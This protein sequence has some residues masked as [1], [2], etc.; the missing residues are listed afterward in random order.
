[1]SDQFEV[2]AEL[3]EDMGKGASRRLRRFADKIPAIIYGGDKDPQPL[4]IIRKDLEK[5]LENEAFYS[6][7]LSVK[8]GGEDQQAILKDLQ[9][10]PAKN[11][12]MHADFLRVSAKVALK[13]NVPIHF[14]NEETCK[15]VKIE[16]GIIQHQATDIEVS[17]LPAAIPEYIEVDMLDVEIG[18]IVHL[19]DITLPEGVTSTALALGED[20]D[21]AIASVIAPKGG[22]TDEDEEVVADDAGEDEAA[23][24]DSED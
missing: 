19:S 12:V 23:E 11:Y 5:S 14:L 9:R 3:R 2:H 18:Q 17:C 24:D 4:T 15:G 8:V 10:H 1:M 20:H 16:G 13:V 7:V 22:S 21:L 6:H